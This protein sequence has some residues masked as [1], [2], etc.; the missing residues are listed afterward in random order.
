[1]TPIK[2]P[3]CNFTYTAPAS[4]TPEE[5]GDLPCFRD[6]QEFVIISWW[7]PNPEELLQIAAG[8]LI[9]LTTHGAQHPPVV[10]S[11]Y[12]PYQPNPSE[13]P[14]HRGSLQ[15]SAKKF[16]TYLNQQE[17]ITPQDIARIQANALRHAALMINDLSR[18]TT[19]DD[20]A[21]AIDEARDLLV[22]EAHTVH[23]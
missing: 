13:S 11:T 12:L 21:E 17:T 1:M 7:Q 18:G 9:T 16:A 8:G 20:R 6:T 4:M 23:P 10:I 19:S 15:S 14:F 22:I 2:T 5:C 3:L